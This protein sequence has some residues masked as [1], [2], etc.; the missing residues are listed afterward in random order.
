MN[1]RSGIIR[2]LPSE[3]LYKRGQRTSLNGVVFYKADAKSR[4]ATSLPAPLQCLMLRVE[5]GCCRVRRG[6]VEQ[7]PSHVRLPESG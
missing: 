2:L 3:S 4:S 1:A 5:R 7:P 6:P